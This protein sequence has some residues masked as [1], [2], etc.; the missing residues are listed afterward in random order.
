MSRLQK[1]ASCPPFRP[2]LE[3]CVVRDCRMARAL[4]DRYQSELY[5]IAAY[6]WRSLMSEKHNRGLSDLFDLFAREEIEHFR[7]VGEL[8]ASLGGVPTLYTQIRIDPSRYVGETGSQCL[9]RLVREAIRDEKRMVDRYQTLMGQTNDRVV[10]SV[11]SHIL[12]DE[13]RH[14]EQ[15]RE[16]LEKL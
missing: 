6:L 4:G 14:I 13:H 16:K 9:E 1:D 2:V 15:L 10:R 12:S 8:I 5:T 3:G 7:L 11:L